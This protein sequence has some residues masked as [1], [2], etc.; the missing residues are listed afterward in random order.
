MRKRFKIVLAHDTCR[1]ADIIGL[2]KGI[3][4]SGAQLTALKE[5]PDAKGP[6]F[7]VFKVLRGFEAAF[8]GQ[9]E[10]YLWRVEQ[11]S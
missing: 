2:F 4:K 9:I 7:L 8:V 3:S 5:F 1:R 10:S 11:C 6:P